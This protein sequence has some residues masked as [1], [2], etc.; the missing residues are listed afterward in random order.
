MFYDSCTTGTPNSE[1]WKSG[2]S[3]NVESSDNGITLTN[4]TSNTYYFSP[5]KYG[6]SKSSMTDL[7]EWNEFICE[8]RYIS[9]TANIE[10]QLRDGTGTLSRIYFSNLNLNNGDVIKLQYTNNTLTATVNGNPISFTGG[11]SG[12]VM[13]R[14][15]INNGTLVFKEYKVYP[16]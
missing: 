12:D 6:T 9:H 10:L 5:N 16:I 14:F 3:L 15:A 7:V 1:W 8:F 11:T 4:S 2:G 13:I